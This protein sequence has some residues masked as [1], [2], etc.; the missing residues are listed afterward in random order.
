VTRVN[1]YL[2]FYEAG[3]D[4]AERRQPFRQLHLEHAWDA[5]RRGELVLA[6][7]LGDPIDG[8]VLMFQGGSPEVAERFALNDPYVTNGVVKRW[9]VRPWLT[10]VGSAAAAPL[11]PPRG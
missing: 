3:D 9:H 10:V 2:L 1:H 7:A 8:A 11:G 6:G 5:E 4:Y